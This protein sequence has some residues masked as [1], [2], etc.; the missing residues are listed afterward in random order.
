MLLDRPVPSSFQYVILECDIFELSHRQNYLR[1]TKSPSSIGTSDAA[2]N[3]FRINRLACI[4]SLGVLSRKRPACRRDDRE[5]NR[6]AGGC[7]HDPTIAANECSKSQFLDMVERDCGY[8]SLLDIGQTVTEQFSDFLRRLVA[9]F[10]LFGLKLGND[11]TQ[12]IGRIRDDFL[13]RP[14][15]ILGHSLPGRP[16]YSVRRNG[17]ACRSS[18]TYMTLPRLNRSAR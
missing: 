5:C 16:P 18:M 14:R 6:E 12:P 15:G 11:S 13:N 4:G 7:R 8:S 10:G 1:F 9:I 2:N 17:M 3:G